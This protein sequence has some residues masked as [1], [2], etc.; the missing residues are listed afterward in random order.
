V[1]GPV[2]EIRVEP[3]GG[4]HCLRFLARPTGR[5]LDVQLPSEQLNLARKKV[6]TLLDTF[7]QT[8]GSAPLPTADNVGLALRKLLMKGN[9]LG[10]EITGRA[11][12]GMEQLS[13]LFVEAI[14]DWASRRELPLV[15][16]EGPAYGFPFELLPV[17]DASRPPDRIEDLGTFARRFLGFSAVVQRVPYSVAGP[18]G[19]AVGSVLAGSPLPMTFAWHA[20]LPGAQLEHQFFTKLAEANYVD[21]DGPWPQPAETTDSVVHRFAR[22]IADPRRRYLDPGEL[23]IDK[24]ETYITERSAIQ[25]VHLSCHCDTQFDDPDDYELGLAGAV[26]PDRRITFL[27]LYNE[28]LW[29]NEEFWGKGGAGPTARPLVFLN[30]CGAGHQDPER[31]Y[32]WPAWFLQE[33]HMA[34]VGPE[35][36]VPDKT[37]AEYSR[38]FYRALFGRRTVG[39]SVVLARRDLLAERGNPLGLLYVLY[40][41]SDVTIEKPIPQEVLDDSVGQ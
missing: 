21:L 24:L 11:S 17:F 39:E 1:S 5:Q 20:R 32:S 19:L 3:R 22:G 29:A 35:T 23:E 16:V 13:A 31:V 9:I 8:V 30:A 4:Y 27:K 40:G 33:R 34:V 37:A 38:H 2:I 41:D 26:G 15:Q 6:S 14:P 25:V 36:L 18:G 7:K 10:G 12:G 28:V